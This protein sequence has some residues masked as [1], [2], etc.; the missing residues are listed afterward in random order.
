MQ[1]EEFGVPDGGKVNDPDILK[2]LDEFFPGAEAFLPGV[3]EPLGGV[4]DIGF[5]V[6]AIE[7]ADHLSAGC[8]IPGLEE[9]PP[10]LQALK[11]ADGLREGKGIG[12]REEQVNHLGG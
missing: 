1:K 8:L 3:G 7:F 9:P 11:G 5:P 2:K 6:L 4:G 10:D 12:Y